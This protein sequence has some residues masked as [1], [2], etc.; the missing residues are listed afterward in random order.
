MYSIQQFINE[1]QGTL[2]ASR[3]GITGQCVSLVQKWGEV[4]GVSGT[5]I[6]PVANAKDMNGSTRQDAYTWIPNKVGD[7]NSKPQPGDTVVFN[8]NHVVL[9][10]NSDGYTIQAFQQNDP[11]GSTAHMKSYSFSGCTG[12]LRLKQAA[13]PQGVTHMAAA[14]RQD[15]EALFRGFLGRG[16]GNE[17]D[18]QPLDI[19][20][21]GIRNSPEAQA[22]ATRITSVA[23]PDV[24]AG[25][26]A[27][28][29]EQVATLQ[30]Q[31]ADITKQYQDLQ[32]K[33]EPAPVQVP[34]PVALDDM[35]LGQ[36]LTAAF[37]KLFKIK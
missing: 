9:C 22:Y 15:I 21:S 20:L 1:N 30:K 34:V 23:S 27:T 37:S 5:P 17:W 13:Q 36:L 10:V 3:G 29:Q 33:P 32:N 4:N 12:W 26:V 19:A 6:F 35:S 8:W 2:V 31:V 11:T 25:Q 28:L 16:G 7:P 18:G 14:T 24:L